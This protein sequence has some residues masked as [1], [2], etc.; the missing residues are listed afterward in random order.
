[1]SDRSSFVRSLLPGDEPDLADSD[2][3]EQWVGTYVFCGE[4]GVPRRA[5]PTARVVASTK[6]AAIYNL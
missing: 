1:M 6:E 5:D 4:P 3:E 2:V